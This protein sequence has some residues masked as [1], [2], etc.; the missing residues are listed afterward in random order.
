MKQRYNPFGNL[1]GSWYHITKSNDINNLFLA[2]KLWN[3]KI[4]DVRT[5][6]IY[7]SETN[8]A[9]LHRFKHTF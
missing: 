3:T 1:G 8:E 5:A 4:I 9:S 2:S 7:G 6:I